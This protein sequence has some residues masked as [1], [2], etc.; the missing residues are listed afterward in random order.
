MCLVLIIFW[1]FQN[2][3]QEMCP[4]RNG[5]FFA[6][7]MAVVWPE[8]ILICPEHKSEVERRDSQW[9]CNSSPHYLLQHYL[10]NYEDIHFVPDHWASQHVYGTYQAP[11]K[12]GQLGKYASLDTGFVHLT[13]QMNG[14]VSGNNVASDD[15]QRIML[16]SDV[17]SYE[18]NKIL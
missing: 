12:F 4:V 11:T 1:M 14:K 8:G 2:N 13:W 18:I 5:Q 3:S 7:D 9:P 15:K 6:T 17:R 16:H 10:V